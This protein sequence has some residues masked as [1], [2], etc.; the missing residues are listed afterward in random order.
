MI[1]HN[2]QN[3]ILMDKNDGNGER[4]K[5]MFKTYDDLLNGGLK[6]YYFSSLD[7]YCDEMLGLEP[8]KVGEIMLFL[9]NLRKYSATKCKCVF[10]VDKSDYNYYDILN[11]VIHH[12]D[13]FVKYQVI[14]VEDTVQELKIH[15]NNN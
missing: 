7:V 13:Y 5:I 3:L 4:I 9:L 12:L 6:G 10:E 11:K 1:K 8:N 15:K 2:N 14:E